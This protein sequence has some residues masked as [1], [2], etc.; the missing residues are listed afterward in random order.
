M[1]FEWNEAAGVD[2]ALLGD[3]ADVEIRRVRDRG[4]APEEREASEDGK[5]ASDESDA[6]T[7]S[8]VD[9]FIGALLATGKLRRVLFVHRRGNGFVAGTV[10]T[11]WYCLAAAIREPFGWSTSLPGCNVLVVEDAVHDETW[12]Y[13]RRWAQGAACTDAKTEDS[14]SAK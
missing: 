6:N 10:S 3:C 11:G 5:D 8:H 7:G 14:C 13:S 2:L 12:A 4:I 9:R 1:R